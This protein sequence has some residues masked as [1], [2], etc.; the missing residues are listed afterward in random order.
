MVELIPIYALKLR[1]DGYQLMAI[2]L[3]YHQCRV[4]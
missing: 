4:H 2:D 1:L 3:I